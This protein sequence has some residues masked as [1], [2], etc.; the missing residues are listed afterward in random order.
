MLSR[1]YL[2]HAYVNQTNDFRE[3]ETLNQVQH[4]R[5]SETTFQQLTTATL[6]DQTLQTLMDTVPTNWLENKGSTPEQLLT[7][8]RRNLSSRWSPLSRFNSDYTTQYV[9]SHVTEDSFQ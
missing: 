2:P 5:M 8:P 9:Y 4:I 7:L 3:L 6:K 1:A